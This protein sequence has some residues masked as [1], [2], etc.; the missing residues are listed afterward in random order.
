MPVRGP[1][2]SDGAE[3]LCAHVEQ[4]LRE[5]AVVCDLQG[6]TDLGVVEALA[7]LRLMAHRLHAHLSVTGDDQGLLALTGLEVLRQS[8]PGEQLGVEEV[9]HMP[10]PPG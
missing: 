1:L 9:V 10:D 6:T 3:R 5:G 8:E 2:G 7:R 4:L